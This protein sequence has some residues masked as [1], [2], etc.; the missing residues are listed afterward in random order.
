MGIRAWA[1]NL[2]RQ[3]GRSR[4]YHLRMECIVGR[5]LCEQVRCDSLAQCSDLA[6]PA[7]RDWTKEV[8]GQPTDSDPCWTVVVVTVSLAGFPCGTV[9]AGSGLHLLQEEERTPSYLRM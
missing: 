9:P 4:D 3:S 2:Q 1:V 5:S 7:V 8:A 6:F